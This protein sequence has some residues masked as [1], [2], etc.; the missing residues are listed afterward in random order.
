V[1][2]EKGVEFAVRYSAGEV[3]ESITNVADVL[4]CV[5]GGQGVRTGRRSLKDD[6]GPC[7]VRNLKQ[8]A[9]LIRESVGG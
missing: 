7:S 8:F 2:R 3:Q 9:V 5:K 6:V 4:G 1:T